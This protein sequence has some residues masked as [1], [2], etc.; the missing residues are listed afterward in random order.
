MDQL[1]TFLRSYVTTS[2]Q[3]FDA[4]KKHPA[5]ELLKVTLSVALLRADIDRT[6][7]SNSSSSNFAR[8]HPFAVWFSSFLSAYAGSI[9]AC[10]LMAESPLKPF[11]NPNCLLYVTAAWYVVFYSPFDICYR[12]SGSFPFNSILL[13]C[14]EMYRV[15]NIQSGVKYS[16]KSTLAKEV[17][18]KPALMILIGGVKGCGGSLMRGVVRLVRSGSLRQSRRGS[19]SGSNINDAINNKP[20]YNVVDNEFQTPTFF[21][22]VSFLAAGLYAAYWM[23]LIPPQFDYALINVAIHFFF[24]SQRLLMALTPDPRS[25]DPFASIES[26][27]CL[28]LFGKEA[29]A[30]A[31]APEATG[32]GGDG[33][34]EDEEQNGARRRSKKDN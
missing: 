3:F 30:A 25:A 10:I 18:L 11:C 6:S 8:R 24:I 2:S 7:S 13:L 16:M 21:S 29:A 4:H 5:V 1:N 32:G 31:A 27:L 34:G 20:L 23:S 22:K 15:G 9:L 28:I 12:L 26:L 17:K 19:G 14:S 33:E